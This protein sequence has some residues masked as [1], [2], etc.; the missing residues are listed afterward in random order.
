M[1]V[2]SIQWSIVIITFN[3]N[4]NLGYYNGLIITMFNLCVITPRKIIIILLFL[5]VKGNPHMD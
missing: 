3:I 5:P 4:N 1:D 2:Q